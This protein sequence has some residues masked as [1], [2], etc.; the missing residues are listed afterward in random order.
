MC[1]ERSLWGVSNR[2]VRPSSDQVGTVF[3]L[4][5]NGTA[6]IRLWTTRRP[7]EYE[8]RGVE[9]GEIDVLQNDEVVRIEEDNDVVATDP[10]A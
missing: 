2:L 10:A 1:S 8:V 4:Q 7:S 9:V 6:R 5:S 3:Q